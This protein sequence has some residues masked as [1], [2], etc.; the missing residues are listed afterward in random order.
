MSRIM[1]LVAFAVLGCLLMRATGVESPDDSLSLKTQ[2]VDSMKVATDVAAVDAVDLAD[3]ESGWKER[4]FRKGWSIN[5]TTIAYPQF[6]DLVFKGYRWA[7]YTFNYYD[8][9]Y[10]G[11]PGKTSGKRWKIM[12]KNNN[13]LDFYSGHLSQWRSYVQLNS[14]VTSL[15]GFQICGMGLSF[16]Y[17]INARDL[18]AGRFIR[19]RRLQF[20][21]TTSRIFVE[22]YYRKHDQS[23]LHL[24]WLGKWQG[25]E[26]F[27]GLKRESYG[28]DAYYIFNH[29]H[30]SQAAAYCFSKYQRRSSG[31][32]LAGIYASH[33]D[34]VMDMSLLSDELKEYL[35][36]QVTD[37]RFRYRDFGFL[38][39]YGYS[40]VFHHGWLYNITFAPSIGYRHSFPNSIEGKK[41]LL[42][43]NLTA[44]MALV[45]TAGNFFYAFNLNHEGHWYHSRQ[46]SFY[47]SYS[48]FDLTA[49]FRF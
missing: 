13:W 39:G 6:V 47:N 43:T 35:P 14:D 40:W 48:N 9:T 23:T 10:V 29:T 19:N 31:S 22:A 32:L 30:Y 28:F 27:S 46:H 1:S 2:A 36:D 15:F 12:L 20:S 7:N 37:Y 24:H 44:K 4:I 16:T 38:V 8:S 42:S 41:S 21:F 34:V 45:R 18:L 49:G 5:D 33:Q 3:V 26:I 11:N 25:D 17:M